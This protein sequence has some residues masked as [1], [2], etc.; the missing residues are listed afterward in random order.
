MISS[1]EDLLCSIL[2]CG[3]DD[4]S[5]LDDVGLDWADVMERLRFEGIDIADIGFNG[6]METVVELAT[7]RMN[8]VILERIEELEHQEALSE[9]AE[10][11]LRNLRRLSPQDDVSAYFNCL[12][13]HAYLRK[14]AEVYKEYAPD[15]IL[16]FERESGLILEG[17]PA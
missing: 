6:L 16:E 12:D 1:R 5:V 15:A 4:L 9:E 3:V 17:V 2:D 11:E 14:K 10:E 7:D 8:E 13:T